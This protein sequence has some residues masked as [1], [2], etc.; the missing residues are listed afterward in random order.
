MSAR[1]STP[2]DPNLPDDVGDDIGIEKAEQ[3]IQDQDNTHRDGG[4]PA[5]P[6]HVL[7]PV[8]GFQRFRVKGQRERVELHCT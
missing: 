7:L 3:E 5:H 4:F 8:L 6:G 2:D 1:P